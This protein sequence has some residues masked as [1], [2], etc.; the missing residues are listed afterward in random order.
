MT[1]L[2]KAVRVSTTQT[3]GG[4]DTGG[5]I[6]TVICGVDLVRGGHHLGAT[7][8]LVKPDIADNVRYL[9]PAVAKTD[10]RG[11]SDKRIAKQRHR[12]QRSARGGRADAGEPDDLRHPPLFG[13][14]RRRQ[15]VTQ[16]RRVGPHPQTGVART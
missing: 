16:L 8:G 12:E 1:S 6:A 10:G 7:P 4:A 2:G 5:G 14:D 13:G 11:P 3:E 15:P 9:Q